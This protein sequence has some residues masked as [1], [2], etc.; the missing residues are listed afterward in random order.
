MGAW[1][2]IQPRFRNILHQSKLQYVGRGHL[3]APA[4]GLTAIHRKEIETIL[5][6]TFDLCQL[7]K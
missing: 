2:F 5:R 4:V 7:S 1:T 6:Q 3:E